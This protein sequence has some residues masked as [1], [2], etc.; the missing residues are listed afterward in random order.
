MKIIIIVLLL[1]GSVS[2][3]SIF[4]DRYDSHETQ[5][6]EGA[7]A[8]STGVNVMHKGLELTSPVVPAGYYMGQN[9]SGTYE[10]AASIYF[11]IPVKQ[12]LRIVIMNILGQE[13]DVA[14]E[15]D[16][17][18]GTYKLNYD[19]SSLAAGIYVYRMESPDYTDSRKLLLWN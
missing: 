4:M 14:L 8:I 9:L 5:S 19:A 16:L 2:A 1:C 17:S 15:G 12:H 7:G 18:A 10:S 11:S 3:Q 13:I 6:T